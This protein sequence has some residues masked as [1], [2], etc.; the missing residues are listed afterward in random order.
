MIPDLETSDVKLKGLQLDCYFG[1]ALSGALNLG[2]LEFP[3]REA[4]RVEMIA[5]QPGI[6]PWRLNSISNSDC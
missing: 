5:G 3:R 6:T 2:A 1:P 4:A